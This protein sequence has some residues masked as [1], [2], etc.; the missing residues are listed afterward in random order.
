M[1]SLPHTT[2]WLLVEILTFYGFVCFEFSTG[3]VI[4][5]FMLH[6]H[7]LKHKELLRKEMEKEKNKNFDMLDS[8]IEIKKIALKT[9]EESNERLQS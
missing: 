4:F 8:Q 9:S 5:C 6:K 2:T 3:C 7:N 1:E